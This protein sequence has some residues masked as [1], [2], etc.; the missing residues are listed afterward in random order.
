[1]R[2]PKAGGGG[3]LSE[4]TQ[5][6]VDFFIALDCLHIPYSEYIRRVPRIEREANQLY[7]A[8]KNLKEEAA[9]K[10]AQEQAEMERTMAHGLNGYRM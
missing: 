10:H 6:Y 8:L 7:V 9:M 5:V 2:A 3:E 1:M 4:N